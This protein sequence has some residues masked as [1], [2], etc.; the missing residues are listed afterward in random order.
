MMKKI[1]YAALMFFSIAAVSCEGWKEAND[2]KEVAPLKVGVNLSVEVENLASVKD[3]VVKLDNY[4]EGYHYKKN[5]EGTSV[6]VTDVVPGIYTISVSGYAYD[7]EGTEYFVNGNQVNKAL[8]DGVNSVDVTLKGLKVSPLV[9]KEIYFCGSKPPTGFSYFR[10]QFYEIYNNS[11]EVQYLDGVY[12]AQLYPT[13]ATRTL[14]IWDGGIDDNVCYAE[15]IWRFPGTGTQYPL[16]PGE[17]VVVAQFAANHQLDIYNPNSPVDCSH[18]EFEFYP[19]N[20][21]LPDMP[22]IN[23]E[24]YFYDGKA[25]TGGLY[26]FLTPVFGGAFTIF[27][28]PEGSDWD[29]VNNA[30]YQAHEV[31]KSAIKAKIPISYVLDAVECI[32][33]ESYSDAKRVP[34]VLDAGMTWIGSTYVGLSVARKVLTEDGEPVKRE[35]GAIILQDTNNSTDDFE[36]GLQP[37]IRRYGVGMPSWNPTYN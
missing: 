27:R 15:R 9:F 34:A 7:T 22:A 18:A 4:S 37:Q 30:L 6:D 35:N 33:N 3:L 25:E 21:R 5:V 26:Q 8:F 12:F 14:P 10:D 16:Q 24:H 31:N 19:F 2:A 32:N 20:N 23:M 1:I 29:P 13:N 28:V 36:R 17:S 11:N